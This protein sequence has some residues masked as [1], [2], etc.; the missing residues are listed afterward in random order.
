M[1]L[2]ELAQRIRVARSE[3]RMHSVSLL[4]SFIL[5]WAFFRRR[6][7]REKFTLRVFVA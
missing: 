3:A 4:T 6:H 1:A 5:S 7:A 2:I